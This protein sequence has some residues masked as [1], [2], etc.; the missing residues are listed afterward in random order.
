MQLVL[1]LCIVEVLENTYI[2]KEKF[3]K[4]YYPI[5]FSWEQKSIF[6]CWVVKTKPI[7]VKY[8]KNMKALITSHYLVLVLVMWGYGLQ[9]LG[10]YVILQLYKKKIPTAKSTEIQLI[11]SKKLQ[12]YSWMWTSKDKLSICSL[13]KSF[14]GKY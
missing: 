9:Y 11:L 12:M 13:L 14:Y 6:S 5:L 8:V 10:G 2:S 4:R 7:T 3:L 1:L